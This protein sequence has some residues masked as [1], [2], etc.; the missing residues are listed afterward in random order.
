MTDGT[1]SQTALL[2]ED[3]SHATLE[4]TGVYLGNKAR[5]WTCS[6][7]ST[8]RIVVILNKEAHPNDFDLCTAICTTYYDKPM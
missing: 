3:G 7:N 1:L 8:E 6:A 2:R 4:H 5:A